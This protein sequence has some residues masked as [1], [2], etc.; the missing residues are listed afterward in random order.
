MPAL[1]AFTARARSARSRVG[2]AAVALTWLVFVAST[3]WVFAGSAGRDAGPLGLGL[4]YGNLYV[5]V[6]LAFLGHVAVWHPAPAVDPV[7]AEPPAS[8]VSPP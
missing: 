6:G 1:A 7:I 3:A 2:L 5:L 8:L 4:L